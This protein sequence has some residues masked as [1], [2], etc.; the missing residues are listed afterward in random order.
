MCIRDRSFAIGAL[1]ASQCMQN[2]TARNA[3]RGRRSMRKAGY[4]EHRP[5]G[6]RQACRGAR[7][8]GLAASAACGGGGV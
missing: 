8:L 7:S 3:L 6:S 5:A 1:E 4:A 2:N